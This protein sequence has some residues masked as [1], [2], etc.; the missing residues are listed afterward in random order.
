MMKIYSNMPTIKDLVSMYLPKQTK[1]NMSLAKVPVSKEDPKI[2]AARKKAEDEKRKKAVKET[3]EKPIIA[4]PPMEMGFANTTTAVLPGDAKRDTLERLKKLTEIKSLSQKPMVFPVS[5]DVKKTLLEKAQADEDYRTNINSKSKKEAEDAFLKKQESLSDKSYFRKKAVG[6]KDSLEYSITKPRGSFSSAL[7]DLQETVLPGIKKDAT[8]LPQFRSPIEDPLYRQGQRQLSKNY[9]GE[10]HQE[11]TDAFINQSLN[12]AQM[13]GGVT[14]KLV[15]KLP[16]HLSRAKPRFNFGATAFKTSFTDDLDK[17]GYIIA[18]KNTTSKGHKEYLDFV[19][20]QTGLDD[21]GAYKFGQEIKDGIKQKIRNGE[22]SKVGGT[23]VVEYSKATNQTPISQVPK[24]VS[25]KTELP[26]PTQPPLQVKTPDLPAQAQASLPDPKTSTVG[27]I[28]RPPVQAGQ[29]DVALSYNSIEPPKTNIVKPPILEE[30]EN[31]SR[32]ARNMSESPRV[33]PA[34][35]LKYLE[36]YKVKKNRDVWEKGRAIYETDGHEATAT[37]ILDP[38]R[39]RE[40]EPEEMAAGFE[41]IKFARSRGEDVS[42]LVKAIS[43]EQGTKSGQR[44]QFIKEIYKELEPEMIVE[45]ARKI[46]KDENAERATLTWLEQIMQG[47]SSMPVSKDASEWMMKQID[48]LAKNLQKLKQD[49]TALQAELK[50]A[51]AQDLKKV[52]EKKIQSIDG[53][54]DSTAKIIDSK[55]GDLA[56]ATFWSKLKKARTMAMLGSGKRMLRDAISNIGNNTAEKTSNNLGAFAQA[57]FGNKN[58]PRTNLY[59]RRNLSE[60]G[61]SFKTGLNKVREDIAFGA[62]DNKYGASTR[63]ADDAFVVAHPFAGKW[64]KRAE[65]LF[66]VS[67]AVPDKVLWQTRFDDVMD[68]FN[69]MGMNRAFTETSLKEMAAQEADRVTLVND[70]LASN[71]LKGIKEKL[72]IMGFGKSVGGGWGKYRSKEFGLG[73]MILPFVQV[74][75]AIA[76]RAGEYIAG[77]PIAGKKAFDMYKSKKGF[78]RTA[79]DLGYN[80]DIARFFNDLTAPLAGANLAEM[81]LEKA[82]LLPYAQNFLELRRSFYQS[83]GRAGIGTTLVGAGVVLGSAGIIKVK[84][85]IPSKTDKLNSEIEGQAGYTIN[86]SA[87]K[88]LATGGDPKE[89]AGDFITNWEWLQPVLSPLASGIGI[90]EGQK[91]REAQSSKE[92]G[93]QIRSGLNLA[94]NSVFDSSNV[95]VEQSVFQSLKR[96]LAGASLGNSIKETL[97]NLPSSFVPQLSSQLRTVIDDSNYDT[98]DEDFLRSSW[99]KVIV[100]IPGAKQMAP[101]LL[102]PNQ[103]TTFGDNQ[104]TYGEGTSWFGRTL[105]A[106]FSPAK[107]TTTQDAKKQRELYSIFESQGVSSHIPDVRTMKSVTIGG[108]KVAITASERQEMQEFLGKGMEKK[109]DKIMQHPNYEKAND[110]D[111]Q[112]YLAKE[113]DKL[114]DGAKMVPFMRGMGVNIPKELDPDVRIYL[115]KEMRK[116]LGNKEFKTLPVD[117]QRKYMEKFVQKVIIPLN[118]E[119]LNKK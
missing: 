40:L 30:G 18:N 109:L 3:K 116:W 15:E 67:M 25:A 70:N 78:E 14:K 62:T 17:A 95:V 35:K 65:D 99:N 107:I 31:F 12:V 10:I 71:V 100:K 54:L 4:R 90:A 91:T 42:D 75:G 26:L 101:S 38:E 68:E 64:I 34:D 58:L 106:F 56:P 6:A 5:D 7:N 44:I 53:Y 115:G 96:F 57:A 46:V 36:K 105:K 113:L 63:I 119:K 51:T 118:D 24:V 66:S 39:T 37:R 49:K 114:R 48:D 43:M 47:R 50:F 76:S 88:R 104:K 72:N 55:M 73:D 92:L 110:S 93:G 84:D 52:L 8:G 19:K 45:T 112:K 81:P 16:A 41:A 13:S 32:M 77:I 61:E 2:L 97:A 102:P 23:N 117:Q 98:W 85:G 87:L 1:A 69:Q 21:E 80:P 108:K 94:A 28:E 27:T 11:A 59:T 82:A 22:Y 86:L 74:P 20:K 79:K 29:S 9:K 111:K 89:Q 103:K 33:A 60:V 83:I